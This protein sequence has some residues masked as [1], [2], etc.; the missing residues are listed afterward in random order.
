MNTEFPLN[1]KILTVPQVAEYLQM[2]E[3][4][5]YGWV[6]Q[7]KLRGIKLGRSVRIKLSDLQR[8]LDN[9]AEE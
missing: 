5:V 9:R 7:G 2:A 8:F 1:E 3:S 4:T 6:Q